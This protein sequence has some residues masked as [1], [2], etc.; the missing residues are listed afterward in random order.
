MHGDER[1]CEKVCNVNRF[2]ICT[3]ILLFFLLSFNRPC[4]VTLQTHI[5]VLLVLEVKD[6]IELLSTLFDDD[7]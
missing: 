5:A 1:I 2:T 6:R 7:V 3:A 4:D